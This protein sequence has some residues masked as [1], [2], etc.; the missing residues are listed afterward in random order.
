M[1]KHIFASAYWGSAPSP[2]KPQR[3]V[4]HRPDFF[5]HFRNIHHDYR[6]PRA[7]IEEAPV[8]A[9][10]EALLTADALK[11]VYLD[12]AVGWMIVIR[13]PKHAIFHRAILDAGG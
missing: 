4:A 11:G 10:P 13:D 5:F 7:A 9:F 8:W 1:S 6:V 12:A 3:L 2:H